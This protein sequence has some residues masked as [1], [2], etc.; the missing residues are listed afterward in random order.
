MNSVIYSNKLINHTLFH[1]KLRPRTFNSLQ[2]EDL[3]NFQGVI[4]KLNVKTL[5]SKHWKFQHSKK[6]VKIPK[7]QVNFHCVE[8]DKLNAM[9]IALI[10]G[11]IFT[12]FLMA[13][14]IY[15]RGSIFTGYFE[16]RINEIYMAWFS[17]WTQYLKKLLSCHFMTKNADSEEASW[18][19]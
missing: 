7:N 3:R 16:T 10:L 11:G 15:Y 19:F 5:H 1:T 8:F 13:V 18:Q 9:E 17:N 6:L 2:H 4:F 14:Y 12:S